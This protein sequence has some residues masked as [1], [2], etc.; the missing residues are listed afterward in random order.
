[1]GTKD[2]ASN[3]MQDAKGKVKETVGSAVGNKDLE[4]EGKTDQTRAGFKDAGE[5]LKGAV[6]HVKDAVKGS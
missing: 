3:K 5:D 6:E 1:M 2:R 4:N